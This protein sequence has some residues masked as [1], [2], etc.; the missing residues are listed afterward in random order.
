[1]GPGYPEFVELEV[2]G[3]PLSVEARIACLGVA[4]PGCWT[5]ESL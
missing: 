3:R 2:E 1:M 4:S 5:W